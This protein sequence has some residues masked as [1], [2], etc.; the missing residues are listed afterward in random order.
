MSKPAGQE[1]KVAN[2]INKNNSFVIDWNQYATAEDAI[3]GEIGED[4]PE[5]I[6]QM[7]RDEFAANKASK[8]AKAAIINRYAPMFDTTPKELVGK[9]K[10]LYGQDIRRHWFSGQEIFEQFSKMMEE[11]YNA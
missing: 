11:L 10:R 2:F 6:K 4:A 7:V 8:A 3:R 9:V 1:D 5:S